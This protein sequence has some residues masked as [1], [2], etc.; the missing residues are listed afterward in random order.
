MAN[1]IDTRRSDRRQSDADAIRPSKPLGEPQ[2]VKSRPANE[3]DPGTAM[4]LARLRRRPSFTPYGLI[5]IIITAVWSG[6][7]FF[8]NAATLGTN[9]PIEGKLLALALLFVPVVVVWSVAYVLW[10]A[11][12][13]R[14]VSEALFQSAMRLTRSP[15]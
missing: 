1:T 14:Q 7:W 13:M 9:A 12:D 5:A 4:M 3:N 11:A 10:R 6:G 15:P 2:P 8:A